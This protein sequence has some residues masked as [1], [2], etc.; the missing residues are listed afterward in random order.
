MVISG[1]PLTPQPPLPQRRKEHPEA[2]LRITHSENY[3]A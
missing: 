1:R 2:Q 3:K